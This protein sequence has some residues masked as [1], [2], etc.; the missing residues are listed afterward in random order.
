MRRITAA[1][2]AFILIFLAAGCAGKSDTYLYT[3]KDEDWSVNMPKEFIKDKEESD[4]QLKSNTISFKTE[5][6]SFLAINEITD[7]KIEI[8]E[9]ILKEEM[10]EDHYLKVERYDTIEIKNIG[11]AY[12]AVVSDEATGMAMLYYRLKY[13]DK[14]VSFIFYRKA[15]FSTEQE[16]KAIATISTFKGLK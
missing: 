15:S 2:M 13:K 6:E 10:E 5:N 4:E 16:A 8:S 3:S 1:I 7:E 11:K 9:E 14:A 12:G